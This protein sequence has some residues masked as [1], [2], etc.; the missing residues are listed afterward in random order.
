MVLLSKVNETMY[1]CG[2]VAEVWSR[3]GKGAGPGAKVEGSGTR[4]VPELGAEAGAFADA[5]VGASPATAAVE[6]EI[7][8]RDTSPRRQVSDGGQ[9]VVLA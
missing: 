9:L 7:E 5:D 2:R 4:A 8:S 3:T 1:S 6:T